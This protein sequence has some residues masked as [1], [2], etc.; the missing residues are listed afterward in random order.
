MVA[1]HDVFLIRVQESMGMLELAVPSN[2][3]NSQSRGLFWPL[4]K[5]IAK[6]LLTRANF[7]GPFWVSAADESAL[8]FRRASVSTQVAKSR[9]ELQ[10]R[11]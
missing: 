6:C 7:V 8:E 5:L 10:R 9:E 3:V 11:P 2:S 4:A 1:C